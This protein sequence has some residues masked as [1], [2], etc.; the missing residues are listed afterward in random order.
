MKLLDRTLV[1]LA[2]LSLVGFVYA[3]SAINSGQVVNQW[4]YTNYPLYGVEVTPTDNTALDAPMTIRADAAGQ[5]TA[6]CVGNG[7]GS[8]VITLNLDAGA[9]FPCQV[10]TVED[11]D[12]D[13]ISIHGFY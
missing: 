4:A 13:S 11:T 1:A 5:V 3:Q 12:T 7:I 9:F 10:I 6:R 8:T 2:L